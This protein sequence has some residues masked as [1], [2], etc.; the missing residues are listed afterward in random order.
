LKNLDYE[1][2]ILLALV[3]GVSVRLIVCGENVSQW[4]MVYVCG[5]EEVRP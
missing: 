2:Y 4:Y 1:A 3:N 5:M